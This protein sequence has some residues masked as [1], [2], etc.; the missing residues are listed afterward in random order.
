MLIDWFT[1]LAQIVNFLLL[2]YLLKRFLYGRVL[3]AMEE[4]QRKIAAEFDAAKQAQSEAEAEKETYR[5]K[6]AELSERRKTMLD[7]SRDEAEKEKSALMEEARAEVEE[8]RA[9]WGDSLQQ[10]KSEFLKQLRQR[11]AQEVVHISRKALQSLGNVTLEQAV[12][13]VFLDKIESLEQEGWAAL[14]GAFHEEG[15]QSLK[16]R[17]G[18]PQA[19]QQRQR[20]REAIYRRL[21]ESLEIQFETTEGVEWGIE[22]RAGGHRIVWTLEDYLDDLEDKVSAELNRETG[23]VSA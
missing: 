14:R 11:T 6:N 7:E 22:L 15:K 1:V 23:W 4:R 9:R 3:R 21:P 20:I 18:F 2:V 19:E 8:L 5:K 10:E 16:I 13:E 12:T 17:S